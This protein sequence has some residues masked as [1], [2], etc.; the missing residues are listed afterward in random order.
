MRCRNKVRGNVICKSNVTLVVCDERDWFKANTVHTRE[1]LLQYNIQYKEL[2]RFTSTSSLCMSIYL[3]PC[4]QFRQPI[5]SWAT[6]QS[7][8]LYN[9]SLLWLMNTSSK[10]A[11]GNSPKGTYYQAWLKVKVRTYS[12]TTNIKLYI[13]RGRKI[14][15]KDWRKEKQPHQDRSCTS[16]G[17]SA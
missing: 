10:V 3:L 1:F 6:T 13:I 8:T 2:P 16:R 15:Q 7:C 11:F 4:P 5:P 12:Y 17:P 9:P 14:I